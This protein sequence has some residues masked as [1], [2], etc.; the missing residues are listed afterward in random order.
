MIVCF[1]QRI[2]KVQYSIPD[3]VHI[4]PECRHLISRI[5]VAD[6]ATVSTFFNYRSSF[7]SSWVLVTCLVLSLLIFIWAPLH[8]LFICWADSFYFSSTS[9]SLSLSLSLSPPLSLSVGLCWCVRTLVRIIFFDWCVLV[10]I[11]I[12]FWVE[13]MSFHGTWIN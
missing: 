4:S 1:L 7:A 9:L 13:R 10:R 3:Y 12:G 8:C 2:L 5:F 6:P 11:I